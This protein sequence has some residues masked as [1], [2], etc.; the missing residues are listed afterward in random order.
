MVNTMNTT[1][2]AH[3][4]LDSAMSESNPEVRRTMMAFLGKVVTFNDA[5]KVFESAVSHHRRNGTDLPPAAAMPKED[6]RTRG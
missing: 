6:W 3:E 4:V 2:M 5:V 1:S